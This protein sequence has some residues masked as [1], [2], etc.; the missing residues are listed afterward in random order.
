MRLSAPKNG[1]FLISLI[2]AG[3]GIAAEFVKIPFVS[4]GNTQYWFMAAGYVLLM[5]GCLF[6]G[7]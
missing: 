2:V 5:L 7:L 4:S 1:V 3:L 6:R